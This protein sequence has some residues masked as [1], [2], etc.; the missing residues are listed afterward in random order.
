M[1]RILFNVLFLFTFLQTNYR[2]IL[3]YFA[4]KLT[5]VELQEENRHTLVR[6]I[7]MTVD[8]AK[9]GA[10]KKRRA[11]PMPACFSLITS[12]H[13]LLLYYNEQRKY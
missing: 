2:N 5:F 6:T 13:F 9:K 10:P 3:H 8:I 4:N 7:K 12:F 11:L 1:R